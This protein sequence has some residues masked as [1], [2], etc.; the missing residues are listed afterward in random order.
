M[1][2]ILPSLRFLSCLPSFLFSCP[3][4]PNTYVRVGFPAERART[5]FVRSLSWVLSSWVD[6]SPS[7]PACLLR[8]RTGATPQIWFSG[9]GFCCTHDLGSW[10]LSCLYSTI[11]PHIK[12]QLGTSSRTQS[13]RNSLFFLE[14]CLLVMSRDYPL[15]TTRWPARS[16]QLNDLAANHKPCNIHDWKQDRMVG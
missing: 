1:P 14:N 10:T 8:W 15:A 9:G 13:V 7:I 11:L 5:S 6:T 2:T 3:P 4:E 12:T 16:L